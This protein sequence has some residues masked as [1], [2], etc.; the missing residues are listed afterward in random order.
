[1]AD[2]V[3]V[4]IGLIAAALIFLK[5]FG[6]IIVFALEAFARKFFKSRKSPSKDTT[7]D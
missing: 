2:R 4:K 1:V 7:N 3:I 5:K 6:V